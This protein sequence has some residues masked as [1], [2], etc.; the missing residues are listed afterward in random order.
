M[1]LIPAIRPLSSIINVTASPIKSPPMSPLTGVKF[2]TLVS[3]R[4]P[5]VQQDA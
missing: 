3:V 1:L 4:R 5:E 2:A